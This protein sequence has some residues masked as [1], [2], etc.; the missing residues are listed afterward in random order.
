MTK[1][2]TEK[3]TSLQSWAKVVKKYDLG[4][5]NCS[6]ATY[7]NM[8]LAHDMGYSAAARALRKSSRRKGK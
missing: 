6:A 8:K 3:E 5:H 4:S 1:R 7:A 2:P